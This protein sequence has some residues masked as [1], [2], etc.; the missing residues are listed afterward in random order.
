MSGTL[1]VRELI[2]E[3]L[4]YDMNQPVYIGLGPRAIPD[5]SDGIRQA[6][7]ISS[8][9]VNYGVYLVAV[10]HLKDAAL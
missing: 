6:I 3:L 5:G 4:D 7:E 2:T 1:T 9:S 8:G 10:S